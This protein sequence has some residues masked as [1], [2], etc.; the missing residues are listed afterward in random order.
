M[1]TVTL[2]SRAD[3]IWNFSLPEK[4]HISGTE[5]QYVQKDTPL[6]PHAIEQIKRFLTIFGSPSGRTMLQS[7]IEYDK[8][9]YY[10]AELPSAED[11]G[12]NKVH[13]SNIHRIT[14]L[15]RQ[16]A[17][18]SL[19][20]EDKARLEILNKRIEN[21]IPSVSEKEIAHVEQIIGQLKE[22]EQ[23]DFQVRDILDMMD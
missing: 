3:D 16:Y 11:S 1:S 15:A 6:S 22:I 14:L 8:E 19:S 13:I 10:D 12:Y 18:N 23:A 7:E 20:T 4:T 21:L 2:I 17:D 9:E 5:N